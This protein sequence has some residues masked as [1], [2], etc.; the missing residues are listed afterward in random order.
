MLNHYNGV[1]LSSVSK[2]EA[3]RNTNGLFHK[4]IGV[5]PSFDKFRKTG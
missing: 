3:R 1:T 5:S 4:L 2:V